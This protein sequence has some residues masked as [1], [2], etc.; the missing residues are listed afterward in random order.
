MDFR[1]RITYSKTFIFASQKKRVSFADPPVSREM[2]Y[3]IMTETSSPPRLEKLPSLRSPSARKE[4]KRQS[5]LRLVQIDTETKEAEVIVPP[6]AD[7]ELPS[8]KLKLATV[9]TE[10]S[11]E[12]LKANESIDTVKT[13][14]Q[15]DKNDT[16]IK[17]DSINISNIGNKSNDNRQTSLDDTVDVENISSSLEITQEKPASIPT[18]Q[19]SEDRT[20]PVT[21]SLFSNLPLSQETQNR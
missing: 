5:K 13:S 11:I 6:V 3:E 9:L 15:E 19:G 12:E 4:F 2:G 20:L 14:T 1:L 16:S 8:A 18:S 17:L 10:I 21:D 7:D